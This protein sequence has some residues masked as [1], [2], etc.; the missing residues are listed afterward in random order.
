MNN[1]L[2]IDLEKHIDLTEW[3]NLKPEICRGIATAKDLAWDGIHSTLGEIRPHAQGIMVNPL[4]EVVKR[5]K[6]LPEDDPLKI[7][8]LGLNHNQ[9]TDYLK[10]AFGAYDFY[11]V[12]P[13]IEEGNILGECS[14]HFPG[15]VKWIHT[16]IEYNVFVNI[17]QVNLIT[18]DSGG[19]PWEHA[20]F[21]SMDAPNPEAADLVKEFIHIKTDC[22]RPFYI[23][24]PETGERVFMNTRAAW[25]NENI[26]HGGLPIQRPTYTLRINGN[27]TE[28]F[29]TRSGATSIIW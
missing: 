9:L 28:E 13:V 4:W 25:W 3:D 21:N 26:W 17:Y 29:R 8:G 11:R 6:E 18:V 19:I 22:D 27:F 16:L 2:F 20:D 15:L 1:R 10:N 12:Y 14:T 7:A 23:I 5:W 24:D